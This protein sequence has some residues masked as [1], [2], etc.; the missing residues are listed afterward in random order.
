MTEKVGV[1][2]ILGELVE[3]M[4]QSPHLQERVVWV[5]ERETALRSDSLDVGSQKRSYAELRRIV[6][7]MGGLVDLR[8]EPSNWPSGTVSSARKRYLELAEELYKAT[9]DR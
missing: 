2:E 6:L 1:A 4:G 9:N 8:L 5:K 3:I 7:G